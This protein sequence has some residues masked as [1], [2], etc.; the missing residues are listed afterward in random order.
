MA[1]APRSSSHARGD[2]P[3][4]RRLID[5]AR[6]LGYGTIHLDSAPFMHEAHALYRRF[7]FVRS[8]PHKGWEFESMPGLRDVRALR[9]W[10]GVIG[11]TSDGLPIIEAVKSPRGVIVATGFGGNGFVTGPAVGRIVAGLVA[12]GAAPVDI[13]GL[14]LSRFQHQVG[15]LIDF[16]AWARSEG[17]EPV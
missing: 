17:L 6:A 8:S 12:N 1:S 7:G 13:A 14:S 10:A 5:D 3:S 15:G 16:D 4:F 9:T 11:P 2:A